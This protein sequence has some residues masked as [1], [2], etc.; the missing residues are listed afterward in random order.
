[1]AYGAADLPKTKQKIA[2]NG[3]NLLFLHK[4]CIKYKHTLVQK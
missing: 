4:K 3:L 2:L 1:M